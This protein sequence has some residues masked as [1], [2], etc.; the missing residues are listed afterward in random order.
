MSKGSLSAGVPG[1]DRCRDSI[2]GTE[3]HVDGLT[4]GELQELLRAISR[5]CYC[6][7]GLLNQVA[8]AGVTELTPQ[9]TAD[10]VQASTRLVGVAGWLADAGLLRVAGDPGTA[11]GAGSWLVPSLV[12][13]LTSQAAG[14]AQ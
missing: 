9:E 6:A 12:D 10:L 1:V 13:L 8:L 11:G 4:A 2:T 14:G 7:Q 3:S 5:E